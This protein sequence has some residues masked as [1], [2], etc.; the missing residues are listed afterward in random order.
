MH[1]VE[2]SLSIIKMSRLGVDQNRQSIN[3]I[4]T[5]LMD[6]DR[7]IKNVTE[8]LGKQ[9]QEI[10]YFIQLYSQLELIVEELKR[11]VINGQIFG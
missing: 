2:K 8:A 7:K 4:L 6:M 3:D 5:S 11:F 10:S 9:I 1:V